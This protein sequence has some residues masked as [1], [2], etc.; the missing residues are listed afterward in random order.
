MRITTLTGGFPFSPRNAL[1]NAL[2]PDHDLF[3]GY[4]LN[5]FDEIV[6]RTQRLWVVAHDVTAATLMSSKYAPSQKS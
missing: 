5:F 3:G 2:Q 4:F 1:R 6:P